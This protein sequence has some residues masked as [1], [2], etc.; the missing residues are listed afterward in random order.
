M[1][2]NSSQFG[3]KGTYFRIKCFPYTEQVQEFLHKTKKN[4]IIFGYLHNS[5]YLNTQILS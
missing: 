4:A 3:Y 1:I 2:G 5:Q